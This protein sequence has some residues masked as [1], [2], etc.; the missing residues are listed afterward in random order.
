MQQIPLIR[1]TMSVESCTS[2][3]LKKSG[4]EFGSL[5]AQ[6][7]ETVC[8]CPDFEGIW[9]CPLVMKDLIVLVLKFPYVHKY[10]RYGDIGTILKVFH[11]PTMSWYSFPE[12]EYV[13]QNWGIYSLVDY[14][15]PFLVEIKFDATP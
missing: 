2:F 9:T 10:D 13:V 15:R 5:C 7:W 12:E 1:Y 6:T 3:V 11:M 4:T 14:R 8:E